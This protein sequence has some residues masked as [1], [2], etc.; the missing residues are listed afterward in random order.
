MPLQHKLLILTDLDGTLL[1]YFTY[2]INQALESLELLQELDVP[3]VVV[4]SKTR[5]EIEYMLNI[6]NLSG[7]FASENGSAV[8]IAHDLG[9]KFIQTSYVSGSFSVIQLGQSYARIIDTIRQ[10][11]VYCG[12]D[13]RG[14]ADMSIKEVA[15]ITGLDIEAAERAKQREFSEPV[16]FNG[17][18]EQLIKFQDFLKESGL[19]WLMG[20]RFLH[21]LGQC[22]KGLAAQIIINLFT[23]NFPSTPWK[24]VG[25]GD[26]PNDIPLL[27]TVDVPVLVARPDNS[28]TELPTELNSRVIKAPGIGPEGW[29]NAIL[30]LLRKGVLL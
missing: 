10:A 2:S 19:S 23:L 26:G 5:A 29:N 22:D 28:Y 17:S 9:L 8:F 27:Q 16:I 12:A 4:S 3:V 30:Q 20:G 11:K 7:I 15:R 13:I 18:R 21:V 1:D 6:S 24:T 25:L 14:F